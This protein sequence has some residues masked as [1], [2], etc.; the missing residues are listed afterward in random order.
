MSRTAAEW[1]ARPKLPSTH[2]VDTRL[3]T[4]EG[5]F[6][7]EQEK[8]FDRSWIIACHES[9]LAG[10]YDYRTFRHPGG[11]ELF[12]IRGADGEPRAFYNVCPHRGN[13]LLRDPAGNARS[14]TCI[15]HAWTFDCEGHCTG[16]ARRKEGYQDRLSGADLGLRRVRT[17][18]GYG[19]FVWVNVDDGAPSLGDW[20]GAALETLDPLL[21]QPLEVFH[22]QKV[23]VQTNYKLWHDTNSEFYHDYM[24]YFNRVTGMQQPGYFQRR[25]TPYPNGH[26]A[27][28]SMEVRYDRY[29]GSAA[30]DVGWPG[31]APGGWIL[32]DLF[33][34]ITY[35]LRT[36]VIRLDTAIPL[37]PNQVMIEFRGLGLKD[38]S[39]ET[40]AARVRDHNQIWG[41]FGRNLHEDLLGVQGQ[42][43]AMRDGRTDSR[44][45]LH[46]REEDQT[47]HDEIGMRH[48]YAT[49]SRYMGRS[50][51]DPFAEGGSR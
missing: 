43:T 17:A 48:F 44:W 14:I 29:E 32:V 31:L 13:V 22:Y 3:Y 28:G 18:V 37:S 34:G 1:A 23:I 41:P 35:N 39:P 6:R 9:E 21:R 45:V 36:S 5:I 15:F 8:I 51:A 46:A 7:E 10:A 27:V 20:I 12:V 25:Y 24:H 47:I 16:I 4:D 49:W 33:P 19:G 42:G 50:P 26:A 11:K 40:R 2:Y 30:R 38:D